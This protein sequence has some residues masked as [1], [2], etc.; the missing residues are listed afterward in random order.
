MSEALELQ[1][2]G[3]KAQGTLQALTDR[4]YQ[5]LVTYDEDLKTQIQALH[6]GTLH[7]PEGSMDQEKA[8]QLKKAEDERIAAAV[9]QIDQL[10]KRR[11]KEVTAASRD[12][13]LI[14]IMRMRLAR[15]IEGLNG[16]R[17]I[18]AMA[19]KSSYLHWQVFDASGESLSTLS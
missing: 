1:K 19:R 16:A 6:P 2:D 14:W 11:Q 4:L 13:G 7:L 12:I 8:L 17:L 5:K 15:R 10:E 3:A 9:E 18:F